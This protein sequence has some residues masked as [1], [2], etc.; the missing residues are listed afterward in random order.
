[1][2][3]K[4]YATLLAFLVLSLPVL[5]IGTE[6]VKKKSFYT[7]VGTIDIGSETI[8]NAHLK[9]NLEAK[10]NDNPRIK[11]SLR[12]YGKDLDGKRFS[13][14]LKNL[15]SVT[16]DSKTKSAYPYLRYGKS[17][18]VTTQSG[19]QKLYNNW[20]NDEEA[21]I[22]G[23]ATLVLKRNGERRI[24]RNKVPFDFEFDNGK[25]GIFLEGYRLT[26]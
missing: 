11:G 20:I 25:V 6:S 15:K 13:L 8:T 16:S 14:E 5:A 19:N 1:M 2:N 7:N 22:H 21:M 24:V 3:K 17:Y 23:E 9:Y 4:I 18:I 12:L 26:F 10:G